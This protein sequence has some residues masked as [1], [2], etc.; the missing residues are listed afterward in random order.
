MSIAPSTGKHPFDLGDVGVAFMLAAV[1]TTTFLT[2]A[3]SCTLSAAPPFL[4]L[5]LSVRPRPSA[6]IRSINGFSG[7][8]MWCWE[9]HACT[10][11]R[12][13]K[14]SVLAIC[15]PHSPSRPFSTPPPP[16]TNILIN[17]RTYRISRLEIWQTFIVAWRRKHSCWHEL[18]EEFVWF[19]HI[20]NTLF[21]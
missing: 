7:S 17:I 1:R 3:S 4:F 16:I 8:I 5:S 6:I 15:V 18:N 20:Q 12:Q 19:G 9:S 21:W 11:S 14:W 13:R 10:A 2:R